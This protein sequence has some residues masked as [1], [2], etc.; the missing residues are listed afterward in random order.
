MGNSFLELVPL[1]FCWTPAARCGRSIENTMKVH[2]SDAVREETRKLQGVWR[3]IGCE[4][5]G[6]ANPPDDCGSGPLTTFTG[7]TFVVT[8]S[9]GRVVIKGT[10]ALNP[11]QEPRA[12]DYTDTFG[13]DAGKTFLAIYTLEGDELTFCAADVGMCR[14]KVFQTRI[15]DTLRIHRRVAGAPNNSFKPN[16]LRSFKTPSGFSGGSA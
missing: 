4:A 14:P 12:I 5:D 16:P 6:V 2:A 1:G 11:T 13:P 7:N 9:N 8:H 15:G 10:F 3:Q